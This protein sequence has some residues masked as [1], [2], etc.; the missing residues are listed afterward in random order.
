MPTPG[1][2]CQCSASTLLT[3]DTGCC[4][5]VKRACAIRLWSVWRIL[6]YAGRS[7]DLRGLRSYTSEIYNLSLEAK[8]PE[9]RR[10]F[11]GPYP[12]L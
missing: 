9:Q 2:T 3:A 8:Q 10:T 6:E 12:L 1:G 5:A 11:C 7:K 4:T